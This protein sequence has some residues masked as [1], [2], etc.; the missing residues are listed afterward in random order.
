MGT[1]ETLTLEEHPHFQ[2]SPLWPLDTTTPPLS[3]FAHETGYY[4]NRKIHGRYIPGKR[5]FQGPLGGREWRRP[6]RDNGQVMDTG[7][8]G[9]ACTGG[10]GQAKV[11][12]G[13]NEQ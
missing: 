8:S 6:G 13:D 11:R 3:L 4:L 9:H 10:Q 5:R 7:S 2:S 12:W 1:K